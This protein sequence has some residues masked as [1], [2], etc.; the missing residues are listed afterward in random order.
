MLLLTPN[1]QCQS[2]EGGLSVLV[3]YCRW[4]V[5]TGGPGTEQSVGQ[6]RAHVFMSV[7]RLNNS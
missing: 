5:A 2:T 1:Q 7:C 4:R 6:L 3:K